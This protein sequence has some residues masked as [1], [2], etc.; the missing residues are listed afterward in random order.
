MILCHTR[1]ESGKDPLVPEQTE[2]D[3]LDLKKMCYAFKMHVNL[4]QKVFKCH[5]L[6]FS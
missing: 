6:S 3:K 1:K 4:P 2:N 5:H